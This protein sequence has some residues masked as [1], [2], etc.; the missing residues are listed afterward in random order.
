MTNGA[1]GGV[2]S[3]L[4]PLPPAP[5]PTAQALGT[6]SVPITLQPAKLLTESLGLQEEPAPDDPTRPEG[7]TPANIINVVAELG[8][9]AAEAATEGDATGAYNLNL[10]LD[11]AVTTLHNYRMAGLLPED[12]EAA[13]GTAPILTPQQEKLLIDLKNA[14]SVGDMDETQAWK[15]VESYWTGENVRARRAEEAGRRGE[16]LLAG[17]FPGEILPGTGPGGIGAKLKEQYGLP[18]LT[19]A[20]KGIPM[21]QAQGVYGQAQTQ[22][23]LPETLP[24]ISPPQFELPN[25]Q[26][27]GQAMPSMSGRNFFDELLREGRS[28]APFLG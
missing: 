23:G 21:S 28:T 1:T 13:A 12:E 8:Q 16:T 27:L 9:R 6:P 18:D 15:V 2:P 22:V 26:K 5:T 17:A 10:V 11:S 25:W 14:V 7:W 3:P 20:L 24:P 19:P 4:P